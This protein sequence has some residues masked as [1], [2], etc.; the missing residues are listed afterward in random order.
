MVYSPTTDFGYRPARPAAPSATQS[1]TVYDAV[2]D[3]SRDLTAEEDE[4]LKDFLPMLEKYLKREWD[5]PA[6]EPSLIGAVAVTESEV[7][8]PQKDTNDDWVYDVFVHRPIGSVY[9]AS[10]FTNVGTVSGLP[11]DLDDWDS[12]EGEYAGD[13]EDEDSN[14]TPVVLHRN[15]SHL[16]SSRRLL[17]ERLSRRAVRR[18][19]Q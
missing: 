16:L 17:P 19:R 2:A 9:D 14:G 8:I 11:P 15:L 18:Q 5:V 1:F 7:V 3:D 13:S 6:H 10:T 12:D 4:Q